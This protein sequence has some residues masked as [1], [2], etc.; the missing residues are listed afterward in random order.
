MNPN[1]KALISGML[2]GLPIALL[3]LAAILI[4]TGGL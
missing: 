1:V 3:A 4:Q 2:C